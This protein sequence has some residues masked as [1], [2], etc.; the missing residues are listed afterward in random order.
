[1]NLKTKKCVPFMEQKLLWS[2]R[3]TTFIPTE[4]NLPH[5][6]TFGRGNVSWRES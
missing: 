6:N 4:N 5:K 2:N 1:M 3:R